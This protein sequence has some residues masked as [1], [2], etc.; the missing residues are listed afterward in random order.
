M[1]D[2]NVTIEMD[3][4]SAAVVRQA[5]FDSQKNHSYE[6]PTDRINRIREVI[7]SIDGRIDDALEYDTA[8]K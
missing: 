8:G 6:F 4:T 3:V 1:T 5:L 7:N 2:K